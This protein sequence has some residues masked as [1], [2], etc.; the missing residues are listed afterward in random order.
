M[1][2]LGK[3]L[4][5]Y[6]EWL[7]HFSTGPDAVMWLCAAIL[8]VFVFF[9][10]IFII[11]SRSISRQL[12]I[13][14]KI[15]GK[16]QEPSEFAKE[17]ESVDEQLR[18]V[19][20]ISNRWS[21]FVEILILPRQDEPQVIKN[22]DDPV[23]YFSLDDVVVG[24]L[25]LRLY[26]AVP[27][28]LTG[29]G[30]LFTFIGLSFGIYLAQESIVSTSQKDM[31]EALSS[32]LGGASLAFWTSVAGLF[33]SLIFN[34]IEKR[35]VHG[36]QRLIGQFNVSLESLLDRTTE[37][38][39]ANE[40]L[41]ESQQQRIQLQKFNTDLAVSIASALDE[42]LASSLKPT[43]E[44]LIEAM[45]K[46]RDEKVRQN[47]SFLQNLASDFKNSL[48]DATKTEMQGLSGSLNDLSARIKE[49][50][51][52]LAN[53]GQGAGQ[54][55]IKAS[56]QFA[57][58]IKEMLEKN[59]MAMN[60]HRSKTDSSLEKASAIMNEHIDIIANLIDEATNHFGLQLKGSATEAGQMLTDSAGKVSA[61]LKMAAERMQ[62][63]Q[64]GNELQMER[65][66]ETLNSLN[67]FQ[68]TSHVS[69]DRIKESIE[70]LKTLHDAIRSSSEPL[71]Q[72]SIKFDDVGKKLNYSL[73]SIKN[74]SERLELSSRKTDELSDK[75]LESWRNIENRY[76]GLDESLGKIFLQFED[77]INQYTEKIRGFLNEIDGSFDKSLNILSGTI[78]ELREVLEDREISQSPSNLAR[79]GTSEQ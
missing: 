43:L 55:L 50:V 64:D 5:F 32:L 17:F 79:E 45:D 70:S 60:E 58:E 51:A 10:L 76:V 20:I 54:N 56:E 41:R 67:E 44:S 68:E 29:L 8:C 74:L 22:T 72:V 31:L 35:K 39:I 3:P 26:N 6:W 47:E 4:D 36:L 23:S 27:N 69:I 28:I 49:T 19:D 16:F 24:R 11:K 73:D 9:L 75:L 38:K 66:R 57:T 1:V 42:K 63:I 53:A 25:N 30:I 14:K 62:A 2:L 21:E 61:E 71:I 78:Q 40:I 13:A 7:A 33:L 34:I 15:I 48:S 37:E 18:S 59:I 12:N 52:D 46:L 77:S 65:F